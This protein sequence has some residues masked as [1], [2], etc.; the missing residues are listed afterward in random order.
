MRLWP[1]GRSR[2]GT[3]PHTAGTLSPL[4]CSAWV[5]GIDN[6]PLQSSVHIDPQLLLHDPRKWSDLLVKACC[7]YH[8]R[9]RDACGFRVENSDDHPVSPRCDRCLHPHSSSMMYGVVSS[10]SRSSAHHAC[11]ATSERKRSAI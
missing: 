5:A 2:R 9:E 8:T 1:R 10:E 7:E 3:S 11:S 6:L 4:S